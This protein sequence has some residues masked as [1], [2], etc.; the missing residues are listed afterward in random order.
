MSKDSFS[1]ALHFPTDGVADPKELCLVYRNIARENGVTFLEASVKRADVKDG[2][3]HRLESEDGTFIRTSKVIFA[4]GI[5]TAA[6]T[7]SD[8]NLPIPTVPVAHPYV[9]TEAAGNR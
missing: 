1:Q 6:L 9:Y 4:T 8:L 3:I 5:W 7:S 2:M